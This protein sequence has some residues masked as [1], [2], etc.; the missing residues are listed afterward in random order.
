MKLCKEKI[1]SLHIQEGNNFPTLKNYIVLITEYNVVI[2][3][4]K[5]KDLKI[6]FLQLSESVGRASPY[7]A[8]GFQGAHRLCTGTPLPVILMVDQEPNQS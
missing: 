2:T 8:A 6:R 3:F 1:C 7:T 5:Q 4:T